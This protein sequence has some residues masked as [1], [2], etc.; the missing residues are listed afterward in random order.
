M[1][2]LFK[3]IFLSLFLSLFFISAFAQTPQKMEMEL[4]QNVDELQKYS[5]YSGNYDEKLTPQAQEKLRNNLLKY[6]KNPATLKYSF[7]ILQ[8]RIFI[9][10]S[11]DGK[12]RVYSW[13]TEDGGTMRNYEALFQFQ[14]ST[15]KIFSELRQGEVEFGSFIAKIHDVKTKTGKVYLAISTAIGS[16]QDHVQSVN[17]YKIKGKQLDESF[18]IFKTQ[19]GLT[20]S[21]GFAYNFFSVV[22]RKERPILLITFD[23]RTNLLKIPI[24]IENEKFP[25]GEVTNKFI[26]YKFNGTYFVKVNE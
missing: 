23:A 8:K 21:I 10:S 19:S 24:V 3:I 26:N 6:S 4:V 17:A 2:Q 18:K 12:F 16:T 25:N 13:N 7:P 9:A 20:N 11:P 5:S 22:D 1:K 15:G 14:D